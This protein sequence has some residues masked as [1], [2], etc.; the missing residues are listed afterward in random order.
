MKVII[1]EDEITATRKLEALLKRVDASIEVVGRLESVR[2]TVA[3]ISQNHKPDLAFFD[4]QLADDVSFEIFKQCEVS[5][6]VIFITAYDDYLLQAF[7]Q[8]TVH[9]LLKPI[10]E[11]K[12][13]QSL[14]KLDRM[15]EQFVKFKKVNTNEQINNKI[16]VR[17]GLSF[18]PLDVNRVA[19]F[20][21]EHKISFAKDEEG[22]IY[23]VDISLTDLEKQLDA[24]AFFRVNRQY[25]VNI[26]AI[27]RYRSIEQS[28]IKLDLKPAVNEGVIIS[29]ENAGLFRKWIKNYV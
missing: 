29:K 12:V 5:F 15:A 4:I 17:K 23:L 6:P 7:Q 2:E 21:S 19:Y 3:W 14:E 20:F 27:E 10:T 26:S 28:K 1:V 24:K 11:D 9:Y 16:L 25:L 13:R 22:N 18:V 8:N